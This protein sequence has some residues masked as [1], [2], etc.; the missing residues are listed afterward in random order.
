MCTFESFKELLLRVFSIILFLI[1]TVF[2][3]GG[4]YI[5]FQLSKMEIQAGMRAAIRNGQFSQSLCS[6]T[7]TQHEFEARELSESELMIDGL[8]YDI[9][10]VKDSNGSVIVTC[11]PDEKETKLI[12][13]LGQFYDQLPLKN[14]NSLPQQLISFCQISFLK[15]PETTNKLFLLTVDLMQ[16][17]VILPLSAIAKRPFSPPPDLMGSPFPGRS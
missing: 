7:F 4:Y 14:N 16:Q 5:A 1:P 11:I 2:L 3:S 9:V 6:F 10:N 12:S 15:E 13:S 17:Q 8:M